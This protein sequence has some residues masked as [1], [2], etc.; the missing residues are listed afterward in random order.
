MIGGMVNYLWGPLGQ[1][2]RVS[3][4]RAV[5][6]VPS[7]ILA[8]RDLPP[9]YENIQVVVFAKCRLDKVEPQKVEVFHF[10]EN[11]KMVKKL[12]NIMYI[13]ISSAA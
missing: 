2:E 8:R 10:Q 3:L 5:R 6:N 4:D 11:P 13:W 1:P 7:G 12:H 9:S